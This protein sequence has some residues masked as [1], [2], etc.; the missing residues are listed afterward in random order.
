MRLGWGRD[1]GPFFLLVPGTQAARAL[2]AGAHSTLH[3]VVFAILCL[4]SAVYRRI[5]AGACHRAAI[6]PTRWRCAEHDRQL[7]GESP[8]SS[9]MVEGLA[10]RKG[11]VARRGLKEAW[12][13]VAAR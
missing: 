10:K 3:G 4:G 8:L 13:K 1:D 12:S 5:P 2:R 7:G 6:R 11:V 9:L